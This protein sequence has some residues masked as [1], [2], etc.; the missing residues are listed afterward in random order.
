MEWVPPRMI[1]RLVLA[2]L[3]VALG[4]GALLVAAPA[5]ALSALA[6][7]LIRRSFPTTRLVAVGLVH[8]V[9]EALGVVCLSGLWVICLPIGRVRSPK[10]QELHHR[11]IRW[12]L[13]TLIGITGPLLGIHV[14]IEERREPE[15]GPVLVF[16]RHAG[17]WDSF[18]LA[19]T[20]VRSYRRRP[21]IVMKEAMQW[22]PVIDLA[23]N[24]LPN[25]FIRPRGPDAGR[26]IGEIEGL[27]RGMGDHDALIL[28]P[29]GGNFSVRRRVA[30]IERLVREGQ[31][32]HADEARELENLVAP[33]P[34]GVLAAMRGAPDADVVFV[35]HTGLEPL[36][37]LEELWQL[38][39]LRASLTG[40]YWRLS[41]SEIPSDEEA[42]VDWLFGWWERIDTWIGHHHLGHTDQG[43][44]EP[45]QRPSDEQEVELMTTE[46]SRPWL[47]SYPAAV[48]HSVEPLPEGNAYELLA[49]AADRCP[50]RPA[51]AWFGRHLTYLELEREMA[52]FAAVLAQSGVRAGDRVALIL[53]NCPQYVIGY[54]A[55]LRIGAIVVG[56]NPLYTERELT[57][58]LKD[59]AP[60]VVIVLDALYPRAQAS[61]AAAGDPPVI[62]TKVTDYMGFPKKQLAPLKLRRDAKREGDPWPP[63]PKSAPVHWWESEMRRNLAAPSIADVDPV[64]D[65]AAFVYTG[66]TTGPSKGAM[67]SHRNLVANAKQS[68]AWFLDTEDGREAIMCVL[69]FFHC[70]GMTVGMN[71]GIA[72]AAKLILVPRFDLDAVM[73]EIEKERPSLFP[74]IPKIYA[75]INEAAERH[76]RDLS[77]IRFCLSG[78]GALPTVVAERFR[79]LTGGVLVEGYGLTEA[80][81]VVMG[82][83]LD[84]TARPGT[85][86]VPL[87]DTDARVVDLSDPA[88]DVAAGREGELWIRG[89]QVMLGYWQRPDETAGVLRDGWLRTG[90][91][92]AMDADGFFRIVDRIKDMLKVSGY[93]VYPT[94]IEEV[95]YQHPKVLKCCVVGVPDGKGDTKLKAFIVLRGGERAT[96]EEFDTWCRDPKTGLAAYRVPRA[97]EFR[98]SL[99]ETLVG[100]VLRRVLIEEETRKFAAT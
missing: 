18:L 43:T 94:E 41:P 11:F 12:W 36:S 77:S 51:I 76:R 15:P 58:Q 42:R 92:V 91:V 10:G 17:P 82:N 90:D 81:P 60:A 7:I 32:H 27:A 84:G 30:G 80:S 22:S 61:I 44:G 49:A 55:T 34:G 64:N 46:V 71:V 9:M 59:A 50:D 2:P 3:V 8:V 1:R 98:D 52:R 89:P 13:G 29:E 96:P 97:F 39:P 24:R 53:P 93:N 67:L 25:L 19:H 38:V 63:V 35:G 56:N 72:K 73:R 78:A 40:R 66:G 37:S 87:P 28:F 88:R 68:D 95:L 86:G 79:Q 54:Y 70:Y 20:L 99:P 69:P 85:I 47:R 83:P 62:V 5:L 100:K 74:G 48:P 21:R 16:S 4:V 31:L 23:G 75:L 33:R 45:A 65:P 14:E 26:F 57:H 6:D